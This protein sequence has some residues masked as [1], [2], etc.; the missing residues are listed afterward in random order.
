MLKKT[1]K[2]TDYNGTE[3]VYLIQYIEEKDGYGEYPLTMAAYDNYDKAVIHI[4]K[5]MLALKGKDIPFE[6]DGFHQE[7]YLSNN[8]NTITGYSS[9]QVNRIRIYRQ[10][11]IRSNLE[12]LPQEEEEY[13]DNLEVE[14]NF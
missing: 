14:Q 10:T 13:I 4:H 2:Y 12:F 7:I 5:I 6:Y 9:S 3:M 11:I 8:E 1:I